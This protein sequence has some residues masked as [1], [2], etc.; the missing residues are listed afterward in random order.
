ASHVQQ[1]S[2]PD[3]PQ[4]TNP[5]VD[6]VPMQRQQREPF[7][8]EVD[9]KTFAAGRI[10][11][12][13]REITSFQVSERLPQEVHSLAG[14]A[15]LIARLVRVVALVRLANILRERHRVQPQQAALMT[16]AASDAPRTA[17][18]KQTIPALSVNDVSGAAAQ[19]AVRTRLAPNRLLSRSLSHICQE[20]VDWSDRVTDFA[21]TEKLR[22]R[23]RMRVRMG[24]EASELNGFGHRHHAWVMPGHVDR[25]AVTGGE[26]EGCHHRYGNM[27]S[28]VGAAGGIASVNS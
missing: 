10:V 4:R 23:R 14:V 19:R 16:G 13:G 27:R 11:V 21:L 8:Q 24:G 6:F 9:A 5:G 12:G 15:A 20:S 2:A 28:E 1:T 17:C 3:R 26:T 18:A 25:L 7:A 22:P